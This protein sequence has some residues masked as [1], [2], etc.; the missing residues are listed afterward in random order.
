MTI[1]VTLDTTYN[2]YHS[3]DNI[4]KNNKGGEANIY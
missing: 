3:E 1:L 4:D 2:P